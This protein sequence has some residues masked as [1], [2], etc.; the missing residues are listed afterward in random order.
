MMRKSTSELVMERPEPLVARRQ[1]AGPAIKTIVFHV[2]DDDGVMARLQFTLSI[3]RAC[4][5][6]VHCL[7]VTPLEAYAISDVF[8]GVVVS[9]EILGALEQEAA[10]L[11]ERIEAQLRIE[12]VTWD[13]EEVTGELVPHLVQSAALA[14]LVVTGREPAER[15]F[16]GPAVRLIG[17]ML[18]LI[19]TPMMIVGDKPADFDPFAP[20]VIAWNGS[21]EAANS[22][23][24]A[25]PLLKIASKVCVVQFSEEKS[26]SFPSTLLLE[27]LSRHGI[28]AE[29]EARTTTGEINEA[30]VR[31]AER[32]GAGVI[33]MGGYSH[34]RAGEFLF[35]GVTRSLLRGCPV[36]LVMAH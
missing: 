11:Q 30:I 19:R 26:R 5:A 27:Y 9:G 17:D 4:G 35:G 6:H 16:G 7:H 14:D 22:V 3:A 24:A 31:Y 15:E 33:V 21:Y 29:L 34:S 13:Y 23:R 10:K 25:L 20:A 18:S 1:S 2:H 12:D 8:A 28:A 32:L 36:P